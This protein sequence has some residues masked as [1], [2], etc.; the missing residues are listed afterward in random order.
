[1]RRISLSATAISQAAQKPDSLTVASHRAAYYGY[2]NSVHIHTG[3]IPVGASVM[4]D[5][6]FGNL[7]RRNANPDKLT[8]PKK[9]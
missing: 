1:M 5:A 8:S 9:A 4:L 2:R 3:L 7:T 6:R